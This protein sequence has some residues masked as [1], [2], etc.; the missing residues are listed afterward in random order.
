MSLRLSFDLASGA[1][2][3]FLGFWQYA[4]SIEK[5][6]Q[7]SNSGKPVANSLMPFLV[8]TTFI[9]IGGLPTR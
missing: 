6:G 3:N 1:G 9:P 8:K 2:H 5:Y 7:E 4:Q